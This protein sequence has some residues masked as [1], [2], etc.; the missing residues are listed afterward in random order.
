MTDKQTS[1]LS[2]ASALTGAEL[3]HVVQ[4][5]HSRETTTGDIAHSGFSGALVKKSVD[6]TGANYTSSTPIAWDAEEYDVGSW[7]DN[8]SEN[9]RLTVPAGV[10]HVRVSGRVSLAN[11]TADMWCVLSMLKNGAG[12][13]GGG[14]FG[15]EFGTTTPRLQ[16]FSAVVAV[17]AGDYFELAL[18]NET[19]TSIDMTA[20]S[21]WF[22]IEKVD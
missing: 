3:V 12:F 19:D 14:G 7:H 9:T 21:S 10:H 13:V 6:Q 1:E 18:Q 11:V 2:A 8:A 20:A 15:T 5:G 4:G 22:A 17:T 16:A